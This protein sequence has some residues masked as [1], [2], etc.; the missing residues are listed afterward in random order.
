[1]SEKKPVS[2][3][4]KMKAARPGDPDEQKAHPLLVLLAGFASA[5]LLIGCC[6]C[7]GG[8][9][10]FR[11]EIHESPDRAREVTSE[12][13]EIT[14]PES[15]QPK[16]TI[17]WNIAYTMSL[18][19]SYYERFIGDGLI[20]LV[21]VNSRLGTHEDVRRHIR[22]TLLSKGGGGTPLVVNDSETTVRMFK[23]RGKEI[24]FTFEVGQDPAEP[25]RKFRLV[26]GVFDGKQGQ[27]LLSVRVDEDHWDETAIV[28]MLESIGVPTEPEYDIFPGIPPAE[29][30]EVSQ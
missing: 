21:E 4:E 18:R 14:V 6:V 27:V 2:A 20:S 29:E 10:W 1:M 3:S 16:G 9:Y 19:G 15:Y 12:I 28:K 13:V 26:E 17:E 30:S 5:F 8:L 11:P 25:S 23:V 7:G 22:Q 24:P